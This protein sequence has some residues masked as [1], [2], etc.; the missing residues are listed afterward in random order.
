MGGI[1]VIQTLADMARENG[2]LE[3]YRF[4]A[5]DSSE[6]DLKEKIKDKSDISTVA[7]TEAQYEISEFIQRCPYLPEGSK[8]KG[9]GAVRDRAYARFLLDINM[10]DVNQAVTGAL[11][12][13][14]DLWQKQIGTGTPEILIWIVHT[15]G[16]GTG[17]GTFPTLTVTVSELAE[18]ILGTRGINAYMFCVGILPSASDIQNISYANFDK[19]FLANS[20]AALT[21]L[22]M[23]AYPENL[24]LQRFDPFGGQSEIPIRKRPFNRYFL[25]GLNEDRISTMKEDEAE[26]VEEYL[27]SSNQIIASMMYTIPH[28]PFGLENLWHDV[29]SPFV[30]FGES[31]LLV[32]LEEMKAI[33]DEN[34]RLGKPLDADD[35]KKLTQQARMLVDMCVA[36]GNEGMLETACKAVLPN[37]GLRGLQYFAGKLQNEFVKEENA[38]RTAFEDEVSALWEELENTEWAEEEIRNSSH[39]T[40]PTLRYEKIIEMF[41]DRIE[42]NQEK[43]DSPW[44][45][46]FQKKQL[47]KKNEEM[48][49]VSRRLEE[50]KDLLDRFQALLNYINTGLCRTLQDTI[51]QDSNGVAAVVAWIRSRE[52]RLEAQKRRVTDSGWGRV[53]KLGVPEN[54]IDSLSLTREINVS[55]VSTEPAFVSTFGIDRERL[56]ALV[57]NRIAQ[58]A[59]SALKIAIGPA[60]TDHGREQVSKEIFMA[61]NDKDEPLLA[62]NEHLFTTY[63]NTK[64][65][66]E[67]FENGKYIF[68]NFLLGLQLEDIRDYTYRKR[69]Y[70]TGQLSRTTGTEH[71]GTIFAHPEWFPDDKNVQAVFPNLHQRT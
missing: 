15:L 31:E 65:T 19:K 47:K 70:E 35:E 43:I 69:E 59:S 44:P 4:I 9:I 53:V 13:L 68:V 67:K 30:A 60:A 22:E 32:P 46:P 36:S 11:N 7:I 64:I 21:E 54:A 71:I 40:T 2:D 51:G 16:G 1:K 12:Q 63:K 37:H 28:Y 10:R 55:N 34:D 33:A 66:P 18:S 8:P 24:S 49:D 27:K 39:I 6:K 3:Y 56:T 45:R 5:I 62:D 42:A 25:F 41:A 14:S 29:I 61:C 58:S 17:S 52:N 20:Y 38:R 57:S 26:E 23:L 50:Q 48:T